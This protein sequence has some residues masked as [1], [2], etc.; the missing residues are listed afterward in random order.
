MAIEFTVNREDVVREFNRVNGRKISPESRAMID[1]FGNLMLND[2]TTEM[3]MECLDDGVLTNEKDLINPAFIKAH[4]RKKGK[5]VVSKP[6]EVSTKPPQNVDDVGKALANIL[7]GLVPSQSSDIKSEVLEYVKEY[8]DE[9]LSS[10]TKIINY[11]IPS[12]DGSLEDEVTH[13]KFEEVL[14]CV[15]ANIPVYLNGSAGTGKNVICK[16]IA[17]IMNLEFYFSN[18]LTQEYKLSGFIDANGVYHE[19]Q[20]YKAFKNGGVFMLDELDASI[21]DVVV[22]LNAALANGYFDFPIGKIYAHKDFRCVAAGNTLGNGATYEYVARN[23]LDAATLNRF[24]FIEI[25]Y[26]KKIE[27][28]L[29]SDKQLLEFVRKFRNICKKSGIYHVVSYR[30]IS[31]LDKLSKAFDGNLESALKV[32]LI[33]NLDGDDLNLIKPSFED[34]R[35]NP[36]ACALYSL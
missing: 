15:L 23:Q 27:D 5:P 31:M 18:A 26:S 24:A 10:Y 28:T 29:T 13:E 32:A 33:K 20:F 7:S 21:P 25:D 35:D 2:I 6:I 3:M 34:D 1:G 22:S 16:Q 14:Q 19:T 8:L 12:I 11:E 30:N 17:D 36:W 4:L 9:N